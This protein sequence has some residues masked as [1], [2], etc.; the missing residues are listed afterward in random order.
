VRPA[1]RSVGVAQHGEPGPLVEGHVPR[2]AGLE[3][4]GQAVGVGARQGGPQQGRPDAPT[5]G[6]WLDGQLVE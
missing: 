3:D 1:A 4:Q 6:T 5:L 2:Y